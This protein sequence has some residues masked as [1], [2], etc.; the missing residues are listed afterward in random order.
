MHGEGELREDLVSCLTTASEGTFEQ[1]AADLRKADADV[2]DLQPPVAALG[3][4][5]RQLRLRA[6][7]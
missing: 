1:A 3:A 7:P 2:F 5:I 6:G 4:D